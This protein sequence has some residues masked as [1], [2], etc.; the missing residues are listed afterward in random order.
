VY[1]A[2]SEV[3]LSL[4]QAN[5]RAISYLWLSMAI[6]ENI[7]YLLIC[8]LLVNEQ[9]SM[10]GVWVTITILFTG[11]PL[12]MVFHVY[13]KINALEQE[14]LAQD[15]K[16]IY[17]DDDEYWANGFTYHN[18]IDRSILVPK[19]VGVGLTVN[20]GTLTG[21]IIMWGIVGLTAAVVVGCIFPADSIGADIANSNHYT[22]SQNR[23]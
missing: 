15:G 2:N 6:I 10:A 8:L 17:T 23:D 7:H 19:R 13:R 12:W 21:K 11:F 20:T 1:S 16:A 3:N 14:L 9:V 22:R 5:R 4:N 18:P